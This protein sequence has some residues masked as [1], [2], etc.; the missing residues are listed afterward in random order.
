MIHLIFCFCIPFL[1]NK[2]CVVLFK[3]FLNETYWVIFVLINNEPS[4]YTT[5]E[6]LKNRMLLFE[7]CFKFKRWVNLSGIS[8][9]KTDLA[10]HTDWRPLKVFACVK[11]LAANVISKFTSCF[12]LL[13][14][15]LTRIL[16]QLQKCRYFICHLVFLKNFLRAYDFSEKKFL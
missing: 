1:L 14:A 7:V 11:I 10:H 3:P 16:I 6:H 9:L 4:L 2:L 8:F 12:K 15:E 13:L 5:F